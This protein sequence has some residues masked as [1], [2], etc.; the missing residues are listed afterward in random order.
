MYRLIIDLNKKKK[1]QTSYLR[2]NVVE[3]IHWIVRW[4]LC[5]RFQPVVVKP[6][7]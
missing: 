3:F 1:K 2:S 6:V 5:M 4:N 7:R